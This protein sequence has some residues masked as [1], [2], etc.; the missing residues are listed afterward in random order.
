MIVKLFNC[1]LFL[2]L[3]V[4]CNLAQGFSLFE[5]KGEEIDLFT[6]IFFLVGHVTKGSIFPVSRLE[7]SIC[8]SPDQRNL[9]Q[10]R[11]ETT[12]ISTS[13]LETRNIGKEINSKDTTYRFIRS[14]PIKATY[15]TTDNLQNCYIATE[16]GQVTK[17]DKNGQQQ[18]NYNNNRLGQV[19]K[20]DVRNP[21]TILVYYPELEVVVV[22]DRT[23]SEIKELN[24]YDF[25]FFEPKVVA[26][27]ND[28]NIWVFDEVRA[29][30][31]KINQ[32][33]ETLF[34]SR[35]LNQLTRKQ[36]NPTFLKE[37]NNQL[38]LSDASN[39][40][41]VFDA[42]GQLKQTIVDLRAERFKIL[43]NQ[44]FFFKNKKAAIV[45]MDALK[46]RSVDLPQTDALVKDVFV[47]GEWLYLT[48][49]NSVDIYTWDK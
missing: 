7:I 10:S 30:L 11:Q 36:L 20:I 8:W 44:L 41:F 26:L 49:E 39:G 24:L 42:F 43:G 18:F 15:L 16:D 3:L 32:K 22:L 1:L 12:P 4:S 5:N 13:S 38:F 37:Y 19:G 35:N 25:D 23:L 45:T 33:G 47:D 14:I 27:A 21:L 28:N 31:K 34:E 6:S 9:M 29:T 40:L 2:I 17:F 46:E 48:T